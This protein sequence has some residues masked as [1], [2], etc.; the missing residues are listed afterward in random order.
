MNVLGLFIC[1][2]KMEI[3]NTKGKTGDRVLKPMEN[4][5]IAAG[6][7]DFHKPNS[8]SYAPYLV[9]TL[10]GQSVVQTIR[11]DRDPATEQT[12]NCR[13]RKE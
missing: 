11:L 8:G 13:V 1:L 5:K 10:R 7:V 2:P 4:S 6:K 12:E 9:G 3:W